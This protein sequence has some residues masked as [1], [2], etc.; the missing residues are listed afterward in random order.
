[1]IDNTEIAALK[2]EI[3]RLK[4]ELEEVNEVLDLREEQ[5]KA[6]KRDD[7]AIAE[8][9]SMLSNKDV[10]LQ[11]IKQA[12]EKNERKATAAIN[13]QEELLND[14]DA[15]KVLEKQNEQLQSN[16]AEMQSDAENYELQ[17]MRME[18][19][20]AASENQRIAHLELELEELQLENMRL[21][22]KITK[23]QEVS[24]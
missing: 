5:L 16:I 18:K 17:L 23:L 1:M 24:K 13:F 20:H 11:S 10:E 15:A 22:N 4:M 14:I 9:Q 8:L 6:I 3:K 12:S 19:K 7:N 21:K 2:A